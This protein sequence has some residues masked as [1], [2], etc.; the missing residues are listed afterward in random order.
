RH[1]GHLFLADGNVPQAWVYF[2][3]INEPE[4]IREALEKHQPKEG[5]DLDPLVQIAFYENVHPKRGFDWALERYGLC[6][7]ITTL[8]NHELPQMDVRRYCIGKLVRTLYRELRDRLAAEIERHEGTAPKAESVRELMA[9]R[10]WLFAD[11]FA[12]VDTSHL[13]AVVQMS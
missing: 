10:D 7:S 9:G 12:H 3:M 2:R 4:P 1:V 8:S 11:E 13:G 5:E 6:S